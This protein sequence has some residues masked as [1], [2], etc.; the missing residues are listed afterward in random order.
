MHRKGLNGYTEIYKQI[1]FYT[2]LSFVTY[3]TE[4]MLI[5]WYLFIRR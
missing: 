2:F 5:L 1:L 3:V 4:L